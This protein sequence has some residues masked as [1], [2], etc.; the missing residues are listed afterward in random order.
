MDP[1][2]IPSSLATSDRAQD[3]LD[4]ALA[5]LQ[6]VMQQRPDRPTSIESV[7]R[8]ATTVLT[9]ATK[10]L[11]PPARQTSTAAPGQPWPA[12]SPASGMA[13][14]R[15][16]APAPLPAAAPAPP[17][18]KS[19]ILNLE[20]PYSPP[21]PSPRPAASR[22]AP[23]PRPPESTRPVPANR[24]HHPHPAASHSV[25]DSEISNFKFSSS[26]SRLAPPPL[27]ASHSLPPRAQSIKEKAGAAPPRI[28][29]PPSIFA[30]PPSPPIT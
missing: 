7:R 22:A 30:S 2:P 15:S 5:A 27:L 12:P 24:T 11:A 10:L 1:L 25:S 16:P 29:G 26:S 9:L 21:S 8:A 17:A 13:P 23:T 3:A 6:W 14:G 18:L 4:K 20:S 28:A 19:R